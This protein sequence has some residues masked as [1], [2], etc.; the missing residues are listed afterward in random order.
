M[1][2]LAHPRALPA[3][4]LMAVLA[5]PA[6]GESLHERIDRAAAAGE[7][8]FDK[9]AAVPAP[10]AEF[11]R[12]VT[13]DLTGTIPTAADARAFLKDTSPDKRARLI[14]R[15]LASPEYARHMRD[16]FDV[17]LMERRPDKNVPRAAW[18]EY[19]RASFADN[20]PWDVFVH[21]IL[22]ADG[23]D[24]KARPAAKF[25]LDRDGEP[26]LSARDV[27]RLFLGMN[28]QC[29]QCH[30]HPLV[31]SYKQ[32][33]YYGI[34]AFLSRTFVFTDKTKNLA[35]LAEKADGVT[36][37]QSVFDPKKETKTTLPVVPGGRPVVE[38]APEKGKE[39]EVAPAAGVRPVPKYSR[40]AQLAGQVATKDNERFRRNIANRLWA[41]MTGRGLVHPPDLDHPGNPPSHPG[42]LALLADE[43]AATKFDVRNFL[44]EIA[45]SKTYQHSSEPPAGVTEVSPTSLTV[46]R[47]RPL[48]P[49]Q[50]ARALMQ[51]TGLTD[52]ERAALGKG[53]TEAAL[54]A[55]LAGNV[56]PFVAT[57]G[58][59]PGQAQDNIEA[60]LAQ[61]LF[62]SN[63]KLVRGW[64]TPRA[65]NL[66]N[67]LGALEGADAVAEELYLSVLTRMPTG[68]ERKEVADT[69]KGHAADRAA[70]LPEL[71]WALL[72]SAE[73][74]FNH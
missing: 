74:R 6:L 51:A 33:D 29:A 3:A 54:E 12:R 56:A 67:R 44:R 55:R 61:A 42:L 43:I 39:Y 52:A 69:L 32:A 50:L 16:V 48:S 26:N 15:L 38:P 9:H 66:T 28:L 60:T 47:L 68:D 17:M 58:G 36:T 11:L 65:G 2:S 8:D 13:L 24:P 14:D 59:K 18:Q 34:F 5:A 57:F 22:S 40:R 46:A 27:G 35:V 73:F 25:L 63:G 19:L 31:E 71:A 20:K 62:L 70:A 30:D 1:P 41:L 21:E 7:K 49:E 64:L 23:G 72:A 53:A 37:Y 10:D 4:V 45:L